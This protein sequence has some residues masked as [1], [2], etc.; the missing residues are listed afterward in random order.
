M[1]VSRVKAG[2]VCCGVGTGMETAQRWKFKIPQKNLPG[3]DSVLRE[4]I[5]IGELDSVC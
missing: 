3:A 1:H 4:Q 5:Q 2:G